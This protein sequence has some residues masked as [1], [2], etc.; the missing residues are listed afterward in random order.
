MSSK[1][2]KAKDLPKASSLGLFLNFWVR[3]IFSV[4]KRIKVQQFHFICP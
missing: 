3:N 2:I 1:R 4:R